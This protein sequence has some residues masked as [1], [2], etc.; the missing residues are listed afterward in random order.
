LAFLINVINCQFQDSSNW[1]AFD[2]SMVTGIETVGFSGAVFVAPY[3]YYVPQF[4]PAGSPNGRVLRFDTRSSL[5]TN[6]S[7]WS[8]FNANNVSGPTGAFER[9]IVAGQFIIF[10]PSLPAYGKFVRYDT[11]QPFT[12]PNSWQAYNVGLGYAG[13]CYDGTK[14]AYFSPFDK[15]NSQV[16]ILF[17][18]CFL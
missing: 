17:V 4:L 10:I 7:A 14:Y 3:V 18:Y 16:F 11:T 2:A 12:A 15:G 8:V 13:G 6:S 1:Y 9:A 5:F